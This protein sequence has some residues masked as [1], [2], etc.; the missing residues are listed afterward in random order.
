MSEQTR[1]K[2]SISPDAIFQ[3]CATSFVLQQASIPNAP[4][5]QVEIILIVA[6]LEQ[7]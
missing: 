3:D 5:S 4:V 7:G 6:P 1:T 2:T